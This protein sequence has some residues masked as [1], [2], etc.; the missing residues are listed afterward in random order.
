MTDP[1]RLRSA[2]TVLTLTSGTARRDLFLTLIME[3]HGATRRN[4]DRTEVDLLGVT[5]TGTALDP[6][7]DQW[8][9]SA[10]HEIERIE[11]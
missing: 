10:R 6:A 8:I 4:A 2:I 7:I 5:A 1:T 9:K 11:K 3:T